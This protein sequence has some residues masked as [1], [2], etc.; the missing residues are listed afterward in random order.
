MSPKQK[1]RTEI[2]GELGKAV[3]DGE[4]ELITGETCVAAGTY[5]EPDNALQRGESSVMAQDFA[6]GNII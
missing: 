6:D 5:W 4:R 2:L 3:A 1:Q